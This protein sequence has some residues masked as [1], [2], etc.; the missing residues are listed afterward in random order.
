MLNATEA[1]II[2]GGL[3]NAGDLLIKKTKEYMESHLLKN[4][5]NQIKI[6]P[7]GLTNKNSGVIGA[8]ALAWSEFELNDL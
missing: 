5:K 8:S 2:C 7:S 4:F 1:F 3:A 6:L